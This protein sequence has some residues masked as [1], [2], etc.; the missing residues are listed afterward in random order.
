MI[1]LGGFATRSEAQFK[2]EAFSQ[3]YNDRAD[4]TATADTTDKLF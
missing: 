1:C 3:T 4:S 2:E